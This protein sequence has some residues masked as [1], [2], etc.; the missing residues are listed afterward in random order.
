[1]RRL[2]LTCI[3]L[4]VAASTLEAAQPERGG[5][6]DAAKAADPRGIAQLRLDLP[7]RA[8]LAVEVAAARPQLL[9]R[10]KPPLPTGDARVP[11]LAVLE[12]V[13][14]ERAARPR[15]RADLGTEEHCGIK[16]VFLL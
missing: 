13:C 9:H 3:V 4:L 2:C 15:Y 8:D 7:D 16:R 10:V 11:R 12:E 1:M 14:D 5:A 6:L